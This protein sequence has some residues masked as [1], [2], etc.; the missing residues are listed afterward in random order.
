MPP[1]AFL[2]ILG[3]GC[4]AGFKIA[5]RIAETNRAAKASRA[6]A[7]RRNTAATRDLGDLEWDAS[8]GVYRPKQ[9]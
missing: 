6:A 1:L 9:D 5:A 3:A 2:A 4:Y 7:A 8:T